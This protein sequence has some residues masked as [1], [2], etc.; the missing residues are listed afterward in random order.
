MDDP[1]EVDELALAL[2]EVSIDEVSPA[3]R[4]VVEALGPDLLRSGDVGRD[5]SLGFGV[6]EVALSV[7]TVSVARVVAGV[8]VEALRSVALE[9]AKGLLRRLIDRLR[10]GDAAPP[11]EAAGALDIA[12]VR[13]VALRHAEAIGVDGPRAAT[14]ADAIAGS[15]QAATAAP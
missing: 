3:E 9:E 5:G 10:G 15:L 2:A 12:Q 11:A 14:L 8:V 13:A 1:S 4:P 7:A 6:G